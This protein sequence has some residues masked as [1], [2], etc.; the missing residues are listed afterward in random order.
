[1]NDSFFGRISDLFTNPGRL[2]ENV[3]A[4]PRWWQPGLMIFLVMIGFTWLIS[5]ISAP[6]QA[7]LMRDSKMMQLAGEEAAD[8]MYEESKNVSPAKRM[9][10]SG[11]AGFSSW[12]MII[13]FGLILGFFVRLGGG[14]GSFNQALGI[15][16]W[17]S[18]PLFFL[19]PLVKLPLIL[20][21]ESVFK[22]NIGLAA[23]MPGAEP[24]SA[25]F[26]IL[27]TYG[28]FFTWWGLVLLVIGFERVF[29]MGRLPAALSV[30]LPWGLLSGVMLGLSL[31]VT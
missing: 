15:V 17:G 9:F 28:D 13:I 7:E 2:M 6:E 3:G 31:L 26:Q 19:S 25:L 1:M 22:V 16:S 11:L 5:P 4:G 27:S 21:V 10:N 14:Q 24:G 18:L 12:L 8:Q 30:L 20:K 29:K 23:L